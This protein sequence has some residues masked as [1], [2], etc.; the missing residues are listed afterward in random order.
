M[1]E[2]GKALLGILVL[3]I[4]VLVAILYMH[5]FGS[6][7]GILKPGAAVPNS[8]RINITSNSTP[9][10]SLQ[11]K[12]SAGS[13]TTVAVNT[14][15]YLPVT[16]T[17]Y[18]SEP[19]QSNLQVM[20]NFS[21]AEYSRY[22]DPNL[23]NIEFTTMP[24]AQGTALNA[25][26]ENNA[27]SSAKRTTIWVKLNGQINA[28]GSITL[29]LNF[30]NF[31]TMSRSGPTGEA[32]ELSPVYGEYDNGASVFNF[33]Y[34]FSGYALNNSEWVSTAQ[35]SG[36]PVTVHNGLSIGPQKSN[37][38]S[39]FAAII[40]RVTFGQ[41]II[42]FYTTI[43]ANG[44]KQHYQAIGL[45][46]PSS[47]DTCNIIAI[48]AFSDPAYN[49]L[50]VGNSYCTVGHKGQV[51]I[52]SPSVYSIII[53]SQQ[54]TNVSAMVN[55]GSQI[56]YSSTLITLPQTIGFDNIGTSAGTLGPTYWIRQRTYPPNGVMP[57]V[58]FGSI[59]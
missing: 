13:P 25:W 41:G 48:G 20:I 28:G 40:S 12:S 38:S 4:L 1:A 22:L 32:P 16:L 55:Y 58:S 17:N 26:I 57:T 27:T 42:D 53:P 46:N 21:P 47:N 43:S 2:N 9:T 59:Q 14:I 33:Y 51:E 31:Q 18:Q 6:N 7:P 34:N 10:N 36:N 39:G 15:F 8:L 45:L 49:G 50:A 11:N 30:M 19:T 3:G 24:Y 56:S 23:N 54:P 5:L 35:Y 37:T 29:Y 52:G 44:T